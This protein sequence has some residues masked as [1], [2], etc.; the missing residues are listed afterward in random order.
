MSL[1]TRAPPQEG[2]HINTS[3]PLLPVFTPHMMDVHTTHGG[4][5]MHHTHATH[6]ESEVAAGASVCRVWAEQLNAALGAFIVKERK[7]MRVCTNRVP[8]SVYCKKVLARGAARCSPEGMLL[9]AGG[10]VC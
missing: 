7:E 6:L 1:K 3:F 9:T 2:R 8:R 10:C 4:W 5:P